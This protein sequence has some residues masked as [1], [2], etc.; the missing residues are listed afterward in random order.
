MGKSIRERAKEYANNLTSHITDEKERR[1]RWWTL[2][3]HYIEIAE[4]QR[5]ADIERSWKWIL[6]RIRLIG[7]PME[8][9]QEYLKEM[10]R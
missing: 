4:E 3:D 2:H 1:D 5:D 8:L 6:S 10:K 7:S 9:H